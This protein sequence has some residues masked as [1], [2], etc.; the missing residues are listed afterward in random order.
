VH[1]FNQKKEMPLRELE[2]EKESGGALRFAAK[3]KGER[4]GYRAEL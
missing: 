4:A 1:L 3:K 2:P